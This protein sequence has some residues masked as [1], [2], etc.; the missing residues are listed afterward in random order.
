L[1]TRYV[2][3]IIG[4]PFLCRDTKTKLVNMRHFVYCVFVIKAI[5]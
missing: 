3:Y 4:T 1:K 2:F 5:L